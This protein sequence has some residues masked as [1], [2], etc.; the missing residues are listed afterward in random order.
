[1]KNIFYGIRKKTKFK[2]KQ[3]LLIEFNQKHLLKMIIVTI[4]DSPRSIL[5][6]R[7]IESPT[8]DIYERYKYCIIE[9]Q[10]LEKII[11]DEDWR[12]VIEEEIDVI[13]K[14]ETWQ[15]VKKT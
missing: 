15:L 11:K 12:K 5:L 14:N 9:S 8:W 3:F 2:R 13:K 1:M 7:S 10:S 4:Q 6:S